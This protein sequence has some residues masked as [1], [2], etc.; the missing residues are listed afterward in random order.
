MLQDQCSWFFC[1]STYI[2][3]LQKFSGLLYFLPDTT[4]RN[5]CIMKHVKQS[6]FTMEIP[7][8][9]FD[10]CIDETILRRG[11]SYFRNGKVQEPEEIAPG[12][13]EAVVTGTEDYNVRLVI[14]NGVVVEHICNCPYDLGPVC[15]HVA[16]MLFSLQ[17]EELELTKKAPRKKEVTTRK[18]TK[19]KTVAEKVD[20]LLE[21]ISHDDLKQFVREQAKLNV[22]FRNLL[23]ASLSIHD[24]EESTT[25]YKK[26]LKAILRS[27]RDRDGFIGW[28]ASNRVGEAVNQFLSTAKEQLERGNFKS[29]MLLCTAIMEQMVDA[30]SYSDDSDGSIGSCIYAATEMLYEMTESRPSEEIRVSML[31]YCFTALGK[32]IYAGWDWHIDMLRMASMLVNTSE[33]IDHLVNVLDREEGSRHVAEKAQSIKYHL[34]AKTKSEKEADAYLEVNLANPYLRRAALQKAME[35][36]DF[37]KAIGIAR[38]GIE[39]DKKE[40]PGL[41]MEW[42]DWLLKVAQAEGDVESIINYA[43]H[44]FIDSFR[45]EQDY[46][47]ILKQQVRTESWP[48][49]IEELIRDITVKDRW[50]ARD[51]IANIYIRE[52]WLHNLLELVSTLPNLHAIAQYEQYLAKEYSSELVELYAGAVIEYVKAHTGRNHYQEAC[53]YLRRIIKLGGRKRAI[54]VISLLRKEYPRRRALLEELDRV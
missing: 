3:V 49:F 41:M 39:Y 32:R 23:L 2:T 35:K 8:N 52:G 45:A 17:Q 13:Y 14:T 54:E 4:F 44:L 26:Q 22:S 38:D 43:R 47:E 34:I 33:E 11:L 42:Y 40:K 12:E 36:Q 25:A 28:P 29:A 1:V 5:I 18:K 31:D 21:N 48:T 6:F 24:P 51:Q 15:K 16:A 30:L 19:R 7:L 37:A 20:V 27:A 10:E 53:R 50:Q 46:Y 9:S